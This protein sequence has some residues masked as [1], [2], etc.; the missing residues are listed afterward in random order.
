MDWG[1]CDEN[2]KPRVPQ[3]PIE[4]K[5]LKAVD[6]FKLDKDTDFTD[7]E[8]E[9]LYMKWKMFKILDTWE[10]DDGK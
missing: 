9:N 7:D 3:L 2:G 6:Y 1:D 5:L 8:I 4:Y 10:D